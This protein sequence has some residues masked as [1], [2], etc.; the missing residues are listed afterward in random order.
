MADKQEYVNEGD[1]LVT[2]FNG[3]PVRPGRGVKLDDR[4]VQQ[5]Q[6]LIDSKLL[7][8]GKAPTQK[9]EGSDAKAGS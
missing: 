3:T 6:G 1:E 2:L 8:K 4:Q 9:K 7:T 5:N